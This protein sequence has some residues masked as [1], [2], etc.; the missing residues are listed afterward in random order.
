M[1]AAVDRVS[2]TIMYNTIRYTVCVLGLMGR[3]RE[4]MVVCNGWSY[5]SKVTVITRHI[6][7]RLDAPE[8]DAVAA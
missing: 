4:C 7:A 1:P 5:H 2:I 6:A 3:E 8:L